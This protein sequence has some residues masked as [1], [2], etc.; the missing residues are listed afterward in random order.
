MTDPGWHKHPTTGKQAWWDGD[1][2]SDPPPG[3]TPVRNQHA[4][5]AFGLGVF[6]LILLFIPVAGVVLSGIAGVLSVIYGII[7]FATTRKYKNRGLLL[8]AVGFMLGVLAL[9]VVFT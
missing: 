2:W 4:I 3:I 6:A 5:N 7:T 9:F 1:Q 8:G